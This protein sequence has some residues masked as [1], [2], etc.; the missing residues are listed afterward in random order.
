MSVTGISGNNF[1]AASTAS[2]IQQKFQQIQQEFQQLGQDLQSGKLKQA[3]SDFTALQQNLPNQQPST[4]TN[5]QSTSSLQQAVARLAQDLKSGNLSAAQS[6]IATVQQDAQQQ[7]AGRASHH[8]HHHG[9]GA[10]DTNSSQAASLFTELGQ[11]LQSGNLNG[12]QEVYATLQGEFQQ[13]AGSSSS[14]GSN[15]NLVRAGNFNVSI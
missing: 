6:D 11:E 1:F 7:G 12:A 15:N 14:A 9:G 2:S 3:Q 5:S 8:H 10:Q 4:A 13:F